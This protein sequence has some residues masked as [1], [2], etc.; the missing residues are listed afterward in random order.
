[1]GA[2]RAALLSTV[3][4]V[5]TVLLAVVILGDRLSAVQVIGGAL[6]ILAVIIVQAAHLW[7]PG[8]PNALK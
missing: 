3:E 5:I 6:V 4:P 8:P 2:A 7:R 1:V